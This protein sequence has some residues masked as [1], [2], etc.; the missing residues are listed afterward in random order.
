[1]SAVHEMENEKAAGGSPTPPYNVLEKGDSD[2]A[3]SLDPKAEAK[4][5]RKF[6]LR[7][8]APVCFLYSMC[9]LDRAN[10]TSSPFRSYLC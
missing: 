5:R 8:V 10:S 2:S 7:V 4:L 1:M 6:R 3:Y 9:F